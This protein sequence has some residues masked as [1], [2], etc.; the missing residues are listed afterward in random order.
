MAR[1]ELLMLIATS[2]WRRL[3]LNDRGAAAGAAAALEAESVGRRRERQRGG[4]PEIS[5]MLGPAGAKRPMPD[6]WDE[7]SKNQKRHWKLRHWK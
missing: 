6:R 4:A 7:M 5:K 2:T 1:R 3:V